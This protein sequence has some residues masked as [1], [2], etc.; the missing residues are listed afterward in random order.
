MPLP[1]RHGSKLGKGPKEAVRA[2]VLSPGES[3]EQGPKV[4]CWEVVGDCGFRTDSP[5]G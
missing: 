3:R 1:G 2:G 4:G 5:C